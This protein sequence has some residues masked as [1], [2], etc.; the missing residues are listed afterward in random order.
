ML[1]VAV[2]DSLPSKNDKI[3]HFIK[4]R[5]PLLGLPVLAV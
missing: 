3:D 2:R 5:L 4:L 1:R